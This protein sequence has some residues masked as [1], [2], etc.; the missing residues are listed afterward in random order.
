[1]ATET[2]KRG[3]KGRIKKFYCISVSLYQWLNID[4]YERWPLKHGNME[5]MEELRNYIVSVAKY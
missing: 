3:N 1:M 2:L 5:T 4:G